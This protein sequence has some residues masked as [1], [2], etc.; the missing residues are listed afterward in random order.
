MT[1]TERQESNPSAATFELQQACE[2][3]RQMWVIRLFELRALELFKKAL[4]RGTVHPSLG[5][6]AIAVGVCA[7]LRP[8]DAVLSTYRGHGHCIAKG[9]DPGRMMAELLGRRI[10]YCK[11][12][13]GSMHIC[14]PKV[15]FLGANGIVGAGIP[16][17]GGAALA[18]QLRDADDV[19]VCFFGDGASN[20]GVFHESA[21]LAAVWK[22]PLILV[23][24]NNGYGLSTPTSQA[25]SITDLAR[26]AAGHGFPG[27]T[28]DGNDLPA[29][30]N[31]AQQAIAR[32]RQGLGPMLI[33]CKTYRW[34]RHSALSRPYHADPRDETLW[35]RHDPLPGFRRWIEHHYPWTDREEDDL[36]S[37]AAERIEQAVQFALPSP[38]ADPEEA[39]SDIYA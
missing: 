15:G 12:K 5:Q 31:A 38:E 36:R 26:R 20:Q 19:A 8:T 10:G 33:E 35:Q 29:V 23:C 13:G 7:G 4:I 25:C 21:N 24:E 11:G 27:V 34:E 39:L 6:E 30:W 32:A 37:R 2:Y 16:I 1:T 18:M 22:L 9:A 17:A 14:D 28:V 3:Y